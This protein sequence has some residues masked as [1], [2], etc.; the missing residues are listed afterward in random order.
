METKF[1]IWNL[2]RWTAIDTGCP[3]HCRCSVLTRNGFLLTGLAFLHSFAICF[4]LEGQSAMETK[5][6]FVN[7]LKTIWFCYN[8]HFTLT[9]SWVYS[10]LVF[11]RL[12]QS[13][14]SLLFFW[15]LYNSYY[16]EADEVAF[17]IRKAALQNT[18]SLCG[19]HI[20]F[21]SC[22]YKTVKTPVLTQV[23]SYGKSQY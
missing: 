12:T 19:N 1:G 8:T 20:S 9:L 16:I 4:A 6:Q 10:G 5:T 3:K 14:R 11:N 23:F 17:L 2:G 21:H 18:F 15:L 22:M 13:L 7:P